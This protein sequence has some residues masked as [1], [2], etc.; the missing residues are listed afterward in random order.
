MD[1][2]HYNNTFMF[3]QL[4]FL[5]H[6]H[7]L[8]S[9]I[10]LLIFFVFF[11]VQPVLKFELDWLVRK[12]RKTFH[13]SLRHFKATFLS[14]WAWASCQGWRAWGLAL[15]ASAGSRVNSPWTWSATP[16]ATSDT[17]CTSAAAATCSATPPSSA[18]TAPRGSP[19]VRTQPAAPRPPASSRARFG[20][21]GKTRWRGRGTRRRRRRRRRRTSRPS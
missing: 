10:H 6:S 15:R 5:I 1:Y 19:E 14:P 20:T 4:P 11:T 8:P 21:A 17:P 7:F 3:Y 18:T 9:F 16:W 2:M 13:S 12:K